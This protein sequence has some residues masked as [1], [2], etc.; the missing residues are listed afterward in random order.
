MNLFQVFFIWEFV[1]LEFLILGH[2]HHVITLI[3][4]ILIRNE[5]EVKTVQSLWLDVPIY[6]DMGLVVGYVPAMDLLAEVFGVD[7]EKGAWLAPIVVVDVKH[8]EYIHFLQPT[9]RILIV[10]SNHVFVVVFLHF[11]DVVFSF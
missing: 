10:F 1:D 8:P 5:L 6:G 11:E 7:N 2:G 4:L 9:D 3:I